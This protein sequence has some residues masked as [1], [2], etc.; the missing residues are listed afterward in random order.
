MVA[1]AIAGAGIASAGASLIGSSKAAGAQEHAAN[2]ASNTEMAMYRRTRADLLPFQRSGRQALNQLM[3]QLPA[4]TA[5][6]NMN[7]QTLEQTPGY[8]FNLRYGLKAVQNAAA[9]R[10]LG[11]SG[12]ALKGATTYATGLADSTYQNQFNNALANKQNTFNMLTGVGNI[13]E[14]AATQTGSYGTQIANQVGQNQIGAGN[15]AAGAYMAGSTAVGNAFNSIP[16]ALMYNQLISNGNMYSPA[17]APYASY[18]Y[19]GG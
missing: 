7:E 1:A 19:S 11:L 13:G 14:N 18:G 2:K 17:A 9:A 3:P 16:S 5:P 6:I 4:L 8:Q 12:A 10:G 15:A